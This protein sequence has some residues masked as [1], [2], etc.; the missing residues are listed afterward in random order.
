MRLDR[1]VPAEEVL[2]EI[3]TMS[4]EGEPPTVDVLRTASKIQPLDETLDLLTRRGAVSC[5]NRVVAL[6]RRGRSEAEEI[7][8]RNRLTAVLLSQLFD[9]EAQE[10][11]DV[12]CELEHVLNR[13]VTESICTFLGHPP[14]TPDGRRIPKGKCC[15]S[16]RRELEPLVKPLT[17]AA[18]GSEVR[19]VFLVPGT[20]ARLKKLSSLGLV[21]GKTVRLAQKRPSYVLEMGETTLALEE[22]V[23]GG[24]YV[25]EA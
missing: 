4:E 18:V 9:L 3:W 7:V 15:E 19:V 11:E 10:V 22:D 1:H 20:K 17:T 2:E 24:I 8:R 13:R 23:A 25:K 14:L 12:A 5:E 16:A 6:T 21:P